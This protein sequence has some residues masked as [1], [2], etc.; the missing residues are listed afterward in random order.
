MGKMARVVSRNW[1]SKLRWSWPSYLWPEC[2]S[3]T[4]TTRV[5]WEWMQSHDSGSSCW[6]QIANLFVLY[7][8]LQPETPT[9]VESTTCHRDLLSV[10]THCCLVPSSENSRQDF[11]PFSKIAFN[12]GIDEPSLPPRNWETLNQANWCSRDSY[13]L[14]SGPTTQL[15]RKSWWLVRFVVTAQLLYSIMGCQSGQNDI[16]WES[17]FFSTSYHIRPS[18]SYQTSYIISD[19]L[20]HIRPPI[21]YRTSYIISDLLYHI[22]PPISYQTSYIISDLLYHIGPPISYRTSYIISGLLYHI[23]PPISYRTSYIISDLLYH[24]R[25]PISYRTSYIISDLLYHIGPPISYQASY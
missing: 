1:T 16:F 5:S 3:R 15:W 11:H 8:A 9:E 23:R 25:P 24:I 17:D 19:L 10:P 13:G 20:Y 22:G 21:S 18:I 14:I 7:P 2:A 6:A 12:N 4:A